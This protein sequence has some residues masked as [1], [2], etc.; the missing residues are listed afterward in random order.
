MP[1]EEEGNEPTGIRSDL[2]TGAERSRC[3]FR[4]AFARE[5]VQ[6]CR[7]IYEAMAQRVTNI[8]RFQCGTFE[9]I[10]DDYGSLETTGRVPYDP[11]TEARLVAVSGYSAV[12]GKS[13]DD[14]R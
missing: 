6:E 1:V 2:R 4:W 12:Q 8:V 9:Y 7:D 13:R 3:G 10:Y 11:V 5:L 14:F